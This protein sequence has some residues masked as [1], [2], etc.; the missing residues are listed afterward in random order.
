MLSCTRRDEIEVTYIDIDFLT[1]IN[2][3]MQKYKTYIMDAT[4]PTLL[5]PDHIYLIFQRQLLD[6]I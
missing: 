6:S 2:Y 1:P 5:F 3:T 4:V